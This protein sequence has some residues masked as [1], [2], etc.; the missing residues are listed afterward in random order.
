MTK[1]KSI[2]VY[3]TIDDKQ[4]FSITVEVIIKKL[5]FFLIKACEVPVRTRVHE[6]HGLDY[7]TYVL[8]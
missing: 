1:N 5:F 7:K 8:K 6:P 3:I 2:V 4:R